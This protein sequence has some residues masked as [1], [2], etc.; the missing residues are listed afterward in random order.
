VGDSAWTPP[1]AAATS[2]GS[3]SAG[4]SHY[5]AHL[6]DQLVTPGQRVR[7][8]EP[9]GTVGSTGNAR[10]TA[11]HLHFGIYARGQGPLDPFPFVHDPRTTPRPVMADANP[12]GT[13]RRT[14]SANLRLRA[15]PATT[16]PILAEL[17]QHTAVR[18]E[19][20]TADWYRVALPDGTRGFIIARATQPI[21]SP[22]RRH[23]LANVT[24]VRQ[25]PTADATPLADLEPG[26]RVPVLGQYENYLLI[27]TAD[28]QEGWVRSDRDVS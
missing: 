15:G 1:L 27:R 28:G 13:W 10:G 12:L 14:T 22:I 11:P 25:R 20:A 9:L 5:Y 16:T 4:Q 21:A 23:E 7:A 8:G 26:A 17:P 2:S 18:L 6:D 3:H 19:A 24:L